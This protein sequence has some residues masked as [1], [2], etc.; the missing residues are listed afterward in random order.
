M[1]K[2][3]LRI[4]VVAATL[5]LGAAHAQTTAPGPY[6]ATPSWD[7][8][9]AVT[10]RFVVLSNWNG[11]AVL[12]RETGLVWQR[13]P[14]ASDVA[15]EAAQSACASAKTGGRGGWRLPSAD[16][17]ASLQDFTAAAGPNGLPAG[18]PFILSSFAGAY[19]STTTVGRSG[20]PQTLVKISFGYFSYVGPIFSNG[21]SPYWCVRGPG[22][23]GN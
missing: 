10:S 2:T 3:M 12:D 23:R 21:I 14:E 17:L 20:Q 4:S 11:E 8:Q 16:E 13:T 7:Q 18:H 15:F 1:L 5:S 19:F 6:Y 9:L 22:G